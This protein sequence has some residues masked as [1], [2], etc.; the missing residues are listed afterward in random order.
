MAML[1]EKKYRHLGRIGTHGA[2]GDSCFRHDAVQSSNIFGWFRVVQSQSS[3]M[4]AVP[5]LT[6]VP[7]RP[8]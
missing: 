5:I 4:C 6:V 2:K 7:I 3:K 1:K 8:R